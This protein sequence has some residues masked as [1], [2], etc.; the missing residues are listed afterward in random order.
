MVQCVAMYVSTMREK[1][2]SLAHFS[3]EQ[4]HKEF[5]VLDMQGTGYKLYDP[6]IATKNLLDGD[7][8]LFSTGSLS[9][10]SINNFFDNHVCNDFCDILGLKKL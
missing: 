4:S 3:Y 8:L 10:M 5:I 1:C 9:T 6:E 2:E 7:E